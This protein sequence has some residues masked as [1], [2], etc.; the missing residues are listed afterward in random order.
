MN[1]RIGLGLGSKDGKQLQEG[2]RAVVFEGASLGGC[3]WPGELWSGHR[4]RAEGQRG[5]V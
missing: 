3:D 1:Y 4:A 5:A 2:A